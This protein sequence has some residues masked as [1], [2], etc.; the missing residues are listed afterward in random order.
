VR[1]VTV[2]GRTDLVAHFLVSAALTASGDRHVSNAIG[3]VKELSDSLAGGS[4]F[5]FVDLTA[6]RAGTRLGELLADPRTTER[7]Q[8]RLATAR[9]ADLFPMDALA[10]SEG[11]TEAEFEARYEALDAEAYRRAV[12]RIDAALDRLPLY[13]D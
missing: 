6:D 12:A 7:T 5:S 2:E 9:T 8:T 13:R 11:L 1:T 4:G 10:L 3:E